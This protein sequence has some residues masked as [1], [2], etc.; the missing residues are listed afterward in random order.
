MNL[1]LL[2]ANFDSLIDSPEAI[3]KLRELIL[4]LA[5]RGKLVP[6]D[7]GEGDARDLLASITKNREHMYGGREIKV[8]V[9]KIDGNLEDL[10]EIPPTWVWT[11]LVNAGHELGQRVPSEPFTYIDV[12]SI[13]ADAG[14]ISDRVKIFEPS[15]A[16]SRARKIVKMG[17]VIYSTIRPYLK[18][19]AIVCKDYKPHPIASTAFGVLYPFE[20]VF[21]KYLYHWLRGRIFTDYVEN[22]QQGISYPAINDEKFYSGPFALPPLAE[23]RRIVA[24]VDELMAECD[25]LEAQLRQRDA[26]QTNLASAAIARFTADPTP[27]NLEYLFH[28]SFDISPADLR[29]VILTLAVQGKLVK[30]DPKDEPPSKWLANILKNTKLKVPPIGEF[31]PAGRSDNGKTL[32]EN[33]IMLKM[34]NVFEIAGGIQKTP[35]RTPRNNSFP[36]LGVSNVQR[37]RLK[38]ENIKKFELEP[39]E[40]DRRRLLPGDLLI[41]EGNGSFDEIGRCARWNGEIPDCVHQNHI[42]RCRPIDQ[43]IG[44]F[45]LH[46]LN[47]P[48]GVEVMQKLAITSSGLYS[49]SVGKIRQIEIPFPPITEQLNIVDKIF[50]F[51]STIEFLDTTITSSRAAHYIFAQRAICTTS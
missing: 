15:N 9:S 36:Y 2:L 43:R 23:Q 29:T 25:R 4:D 1:E 37:G 42:I 32:P 20:G 18:N 10:P 24:R 41:I 27:A 14:V 30:Q 28:D 26:H 5:V 40:I 13:D 38:L 35:L 22:C 49:L 17:T 51:Y 50:S 34:E 8:R 16:P 48:A 47:S 21:Q 44:E 31:N 46:Y 6:Q 33:W 3:P 39:G 7:P 12:G 19:I 11:T 45:V